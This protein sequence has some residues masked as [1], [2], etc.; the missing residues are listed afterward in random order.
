MGFFE[1]LNP[2]KYDRQYSDGQL[3]RRIWEYFRPQTGRLIG[4]MVLVIALGA[5]FAA[6]PLFIGWL[7]DLL[8]GQP[9]LQLIALT[10]AVLVVMAFLQWGMNWARRSLVA[11]SVGDVVLE[12]RVRA[13][14]AAS[15]HDLSF[16][17]QFSSGRIVSRITS[18]SNDFGQLVVISTE[19]GSEVLH[20]VIL[21]VV[22]IRTE[23]HMA[24]L[25][26]SFM[27]VIVALTLGFRS[28]ARRVTR[29]G[30]QAMADVN[31]A[32]KETVSGI[33]IAKNF[34]Q[35][36]SIFGTFDSAN[37]QSYRVNV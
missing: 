12:L 24:L 20:A 7:V 9:S 6:F 17:D 32:I 14:K 27:P 4:I 26:F 31:A 16:Y 3:L 33:S 18:D 28:L 35:E 8:G 2:E 10:G 5:V 1:G 29:R 19:L 34:R 25:L 36:Q 30:M 37:Q 13:F 22:L 23:W 15:A 21:A 11:R